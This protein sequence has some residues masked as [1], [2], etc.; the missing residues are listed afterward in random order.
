MSADLS[1]FLQVGEYLLEQTIPGLNQLL[2]QAGMRGHP[3]HPLLAPL[4]ALDHLRMVFWQNAS[5]RIDTYGEQWLKTVPP[6][7]SRLLRTASGKHL[8]KVAWEAHLA[9]EATLNNRRAFFSDPQNLKG[10]HLLVTPHASTPPC[11]RLQRAL[12]EAMSG[13]QAGC[14]PVAGPMVVPQL[15]CPW[16][17]PST[18]M[19]CMAL[20]PWGAAAGGGGSYGVQLPPQRGAPSSAPHVKDVLLLEKQVL[21]ASMTF[22]MV[23]AQDGEGLPN[24]LHCDAGMEAV[25]LHYSCRGIRGLCQGCGCAPRSASVAWFPQ[26]GEGQQHG[27]FTVQGRPCC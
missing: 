17:Q 12:L 6:A 23:Q 14:L 26:G 27:L 10:G 21:R 11:D 4:R 7:A 24:P 2:R 18:P 9:A 20:F 5:L 16:V 15:Q 8:R 13:R 3:A 25:R 22:R 1:R 19:E